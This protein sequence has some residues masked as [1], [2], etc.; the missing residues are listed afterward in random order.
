MADER[1]D[2]D[3]SGAL[4]DIAQL[5]TGLSGLQAGAKKA[6][7]AF[8][9]AFSA[10]EAQGVADALDDLQRQYDSLKKSADT[11][12]TSLK[13]A[14]NPELIKLYA[15]NIAKLEA[16][17]KRLEYTGK[18]AGVNL[19]KVN[20][21]AGTGRQVFENFFGAFTKASIIIAA[22]EAVIK[23]TSYAV[24]LSESLNKS[25]K[26]FE[27]FTG[28]AAE[29]DKIVQQLTETG[30]RLGLPT[31]ELLKAGK[32]LLAFGEEADNLP[33]VLSQIADVSA[34]TGKELGALTE[35]YGRSL[36]AGT[37]SQDD[38]NQLFEAGV[39]TLK[40]LAKQMGITED[41]VKQLGSQGKISFEEL[42]LALFDATQEGGKFA[43]QAEKNLD[44][45]GGAWNKLLAKLQPGIAAVGGFLSDLAQG[46]IL[47]VTNIIEGIESLFDKSGKAAIK[48]AQELN[49]E[50]KEEMYAS[51][52]EYE[53]D[54]QFRDELDRKTKEKREALAKANAA[55]LAKI[56]KERNALRIQAMKDGEEKEIAIENARFAEL[57]KQ[58]EKYHLDTKE[59]TEQ[60]EQ[61]ILKIQAKYFVER[62]NAEQEAIELQKEQEQELIDFDNKQ[63]ADRVANAKKRAEDIFNVRESEI[64]LLEQQY[65]NYLAQM[66]SDGADE[67]AIGEQQIKF[68]N[69]IQ[70]ERLKNQIAFQEAILSTLDAGDT[71]AIEQAKNNIARL[72][73]ALEGVSI[74]IPRPD[75]SG[76]TLFEGLG[77]NEDQIAEIQRGAD[78]LISIIND[79]SA[80]QVEKAERAIDAANREQEAA[81]AFYD[82]QK[83]LNEQGFAND[84]DLAERRLQ[85]AA[86]QEERAIAQK[87]KAQRQQILIESALQAANIATA[88]SQTFKEFPGAL[89]PIAVGLVALMIGAF[90]ASKARA[91]QA[92]K[93]RD[94]G[95]GRVDGRGIIVGNSHERGGVGFEAEGGEFFTTNGERFG[96]VNKRM[97]AKHFD[98]LQAINTD[99]RDKMRDALAAL[100]APIDRDRVIGAA[101]GSVAVV[102]GKDRDTYNLLKDWKK[103]AG[104]RKTVTVANGYIIEQVGNATRKIRIR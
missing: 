63:A 48:N 3:V 17:M 98:L 30:M 20:K 74:N 53:K 102:V 68:D 39:F 89:T 25:R 82:E 56:E 66:R 50:G 47:N 75:G 58:L 10:D 65:A 18:A 4:R 64:N 31:D 101:G 91:L 43:D 99:N 57:K 90:I 23:F 19:Q 54:I 8:N 95:G 78:N 72:K 69:V 16:G 27:A 79:V 6:G 13:N 15:S 46:F 80:A 2:I 104:K 86:Q 76:G 35:I 26:Q 45:L 60:H 32:S 34:A 103:E 67:K 59:A 40:D 52:R 7:A 11:L 96:I 38:L 71:A 41:Q 70:A 21:E 28:S 77:F 14:T 92:T 88:A 100:V 29:A 37:V 87:K 85:A 93:F 22:I 42:Q 83:A 62:F 9:D 12:K 36:N 73:A 94:G 33:R 81:R 44:T 49:D 5:N 84:F 55:E 1:I 51:R 97:T 61:N 24:G